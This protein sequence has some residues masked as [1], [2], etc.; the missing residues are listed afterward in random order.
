MTI[1]GIRDGARSYGCW[2]WR[3]SSNH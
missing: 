1:L 3:S 2:L